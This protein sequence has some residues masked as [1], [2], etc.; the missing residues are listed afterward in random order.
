MAQIDQMVF[1]RGPEELPAG[2]QESLA[3]KI[4]PLGERS[5]RECTWMVFP[6]EVPEEG[7]L[8]PQKI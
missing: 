1:Q 4:A 7:V 8:G 3:V 6:R 2:S 5:F